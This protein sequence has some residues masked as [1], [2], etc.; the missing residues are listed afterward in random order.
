M[1]YSDY[2][3]G[4]RDGYSIGYL[5]GYRGGYKVGYLSGYIDGYGDNSCG[6]FYDPIAEAREQ[7]LK[8]ESI[9]EKLRAGRMAAYETFVPVVEPVLP[10]VF[11]YA[12]LPN[13]D[14]M[15]VSYYDVA[16]MRWRYK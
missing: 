3:A 12:P 9:C 10:R 7:R 8:H 4:F 16:A 5:C 11:S 13:T 14:D 2:M 1:S 6:K 15:F